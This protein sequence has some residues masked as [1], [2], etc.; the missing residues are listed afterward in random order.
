MERESPAEEF[1]RYRR[2]SRASQRSPIY[3]VPK[4]HAG[5][6]VYISKAPRIDRDRMC[7]FSG[8]V[9]HSVDRDDKLRVIRHKEGI[10][11]LEIRRLIACISP[12]FRNRL[13]SYDVCRDEEGEYGDVDCLKATPIMWD[14]NE[15][16]RLRKL[17]ILFD[18]D[19]VR[20][21]VMDTIYIALG[22]TE[23]R[24][25]LRDPVRRG[26]V[27]ELLYRTMDTD[28]VECRFWSDMAAGMKL[29]RFL[30][31]HHPGHQVLLWKC[32]PWRL[33]P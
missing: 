21:L 16:W 19:C 7:R 33:T 27:I 10:S 12:T 9:Q 30:D 22:R 18:V 1:S 29:N 8:H 15:L 26:T 3:F 31:L 32:P 5:D 6:L 25:G 2:N 14:L 24:G 20:D 17:A 4:E 13:P 23:Q 28:A 11:P